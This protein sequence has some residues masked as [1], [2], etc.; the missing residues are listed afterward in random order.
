MKRHPAYI[1]LA[2][3][4]AGV[5]FSTAAQAQRAREPGNIV[6]GGGGAAA[7]GGGDNMTIVYSAMGAGAG[8]GVQAQTGLPARIVGNDGDGLQVEYTGALPPGAG[9]HARVYEGEVTY[10]DE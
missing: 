9:R 10:L 7:Y 1:A 5:A 2:I 4:A 3:L 6:G 8:G